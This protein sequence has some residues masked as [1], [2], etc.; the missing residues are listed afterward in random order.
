[1]YPLIKAKISN[2]I[3]SK[4]NEVESEKSNKLPIK[5]SNLKK[6]QILNKNIWKSFNKGKICRKQLNSNEQKNEYEKIKN[7]SEQLLVDN[8]NRNTSFDRIIKSLTGYSISRCCYVNNKKA[9][10]WKI[11]IN[12][13]KNEATLS[14]NSNCDHENQRKNKSLFVLLYNLL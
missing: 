14:S 3:K 9:C 12:I 4:R 10:F 1:V 13:N 11:N 7:V 8:L 2:C 6:D 5:A